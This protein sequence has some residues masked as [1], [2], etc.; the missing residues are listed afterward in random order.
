MDSYTKS[1]FVGCN[2]SVNSD[3]VTPFSNPANIQ[4]SGG[5]FTFI[6]GFT[7][8]RNP[9]WKQQIRRGVNATTSYVGSD[10]EV[11]DIYFTIEGGADFPC[12]NPNLVNQSALKWHII[13]GGYL[14]VTDPTIF[15]DPD[16]D[17]RAEVTNR[18]IRKFISTC[19][20][21]LSSLELGQDLGEL[22]ETVHSIHRPLG[23]LQDKLINY[24]SRLKKVK[25][26]VRSAKALRKVLADTYLE[27]H[28]GIQPVVDDVT[29]IITDI[30][31]FRYP[32]YPV[33]ASASGTYNGS[34]NETAI[35]NPGY[36]SNFQPAG[37]SVIPKRRVRL[38]PQSRGRRA[39][40][41]RAKGHGDEPWTKYE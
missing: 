4:A 41:S 19:Q 10:A 28:F 26:T 17:M 18:C 11:S 20:D 33:S 15:A 39:S 5:N 2:W 25:S 29:K 31:R 9:S 32:V 14:Q 23:S 37:L 36:A 34:A 3:E 12:T 38:I 40:Y 16:A 1:K 35:G 8:S 24:V 30:G 27:F 22:K 7:G 21:K 6:G 13:T